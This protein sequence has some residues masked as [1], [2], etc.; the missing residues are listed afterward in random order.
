MLCDQRRNLGRGE[1]PLSVDRDGIAAQLRTEVLLVAAAR[2]ERRVQGR[3][4]DEPDE[5]AIV[6][7]EPQPP[8]HLHQRVLLLGGSTVVRDRET[9]DGEAPRETVPTDEDAPHG[10]LVEIDL[11]V[12]QTLVAVHDDYRVAGLADVRTAWATYG[13]RSS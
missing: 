5:I 13:V 6:R 8:S 1:L 10:T 4:D 2:L 11:L 7:S 9:L 3:I 12:L